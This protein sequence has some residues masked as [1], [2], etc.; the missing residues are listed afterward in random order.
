MCR[1]PDC[2]SRAKRMAQSRFWVKIPAD[3]PNRESLAMAMASLMS[4]KALTATAGPKS[5]SLETRMSGLTSA[6]TVGE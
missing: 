1:L 2:T 6:T 4:V 3:R 5:S